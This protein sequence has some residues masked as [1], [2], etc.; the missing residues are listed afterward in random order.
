MPTKHLTKTPFIVS[1]M[2]KQLQ[3]V[4]L[5]IKFLLSNV[6]NSIYMTTQVFYTLLKHLQSREWRDKQTRQ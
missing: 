2:K 5:Q 6:M 3:I 1:Q 4:K